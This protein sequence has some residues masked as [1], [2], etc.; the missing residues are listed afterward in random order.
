[1]HM[2]THVLEDSCV[3]DTKTTTDKDHT[4][5]IY[6]TCTFVKWIHYLSQLLSSNATVFF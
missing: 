4:N 3:P 5:N 1:M 2:H 6:Q